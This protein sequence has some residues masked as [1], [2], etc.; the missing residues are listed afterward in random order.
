M[1]CFLRGLTR[2]EGPLPRPGQA[3]QNPFQ[4]LIHLAPAAGLPALAQ[5]H[6]P[7]C[8]RAVPAVG[9][10]PSRPTPRL[11]LAA[12]LL[13]PTAI[14][15]RHAPAQPWLTQPPLPPAVRWTSATSW[16]TIRRTTSPLPP[17]PPGSPPPHQ[18]ERAYRCALL[19]HPDKICGWGTNAGRIS[20]RS[21]CR[22]GRS[23]LRRW[24][25][26]SSRCRPVR[27]ET[28]PS[29]ISRRPPCDSRARSM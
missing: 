25:T 28:A 14:H 13:P 5:L 17:A 26:P 22:R 1:W 21:A 8:A 15:P 4:T 18:R 6:P 27:T 7:F 20:G 19:Q 9:Q 16:R 11:L 10:N 23:W 3:A 12:S 2:R 24:P 29:S